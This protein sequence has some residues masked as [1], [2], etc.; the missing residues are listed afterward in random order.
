MDSGPIGFVRGVDD[1]GASP[2][3]GFPYRFAVLTW[4]E[5]EREMGDPWL[6]MRS[7]FPRTA[8]LVGGDSIVAEYWERHRRTVLFWE[9]KERKVREVSWESLMER[10]EEALLDEEF[11]SRLRFL[12]GGRTVLHAESEMWNLVGG[13][14]PFHDSVTVS[15]FSACAI[16]EALQGIFTEEAAKHGLS[17]LNTHEAEQGGGATA[18][19]RVDHP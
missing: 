8:A 19:P 5:N 1:H 2:P 13:P 16:D 17:V 14:S 11:P 9:W 18:L 3:A 15:F 7:A 4:L 10:T 12:C 6:L